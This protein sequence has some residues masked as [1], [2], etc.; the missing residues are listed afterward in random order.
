MLGWLLYWLCGTTKR[1]RQQAEIDR[2][3]HVGHELTA[4][5]DR[6]RA[7]R[8]KAIA[9]RDSLKAEHDEAREVWRHYCDSL[10]E[11][12]DEAIAERD[13]ANQQASRHEAST[14]H[15]VK[16]LYSTMI[17]LN[18]AEALLD[19]AAATIDRLKAE[20]DG[21][22]LVFAEAMEM[23]SATC[24]ELNRSR[25]DLSKIRDAVRATEENQ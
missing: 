17:D 25:S 13:K 5:I 22:R 21:S 8:D 1:Q 2:L 10:R 15:L 6:L 16:V 12:R 9:E 14:N 24:R 18:A 23:L 3:S 11:H 19:E 20:R 4:V 7:E